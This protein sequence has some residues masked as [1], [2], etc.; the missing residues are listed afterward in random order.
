MTHLLE[1]I[2]SRLAFTG[3]KDVIKVEIPAEVVVPKVETSR[4]VS[5][6]TEFEETVGN[7]VRIYRISITTA[8]TFKRKE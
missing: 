5:V 8:L 1:I 2:R 3:N 4:E 6:K 7:G